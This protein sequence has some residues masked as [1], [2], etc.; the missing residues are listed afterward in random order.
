[1]RI[2]YGTLVI[3]SLSVALVAYVIAALMEV[4]KK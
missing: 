3:I 2:D 4:L 1:M